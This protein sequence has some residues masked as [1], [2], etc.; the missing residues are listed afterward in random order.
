[1][2]DSTFLRFLRS[3]SCATYSLNDGDN[4]QEMIASEHEDESKEGGAPEQQQAV[5]VLIKRR[6]SR[7]WSGCLTSPSSD[8]FH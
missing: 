7:V 3:G 4:G 1:M 8:T 6:L 2:K 5:I